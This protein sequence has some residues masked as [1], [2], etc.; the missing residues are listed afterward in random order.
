[1]QG[2]LRSAIVLALVCLIALTL[3]CG[4]TEIRVRPTTGLRGFHTD[5]EE[6]TSLLA[7]SQTTGTVQL[8]QPDGNTDFVVEEDAVMSSGEEPN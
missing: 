8:Q 3:N 6:S 5:F 7:I 2:K 1:M 4:P